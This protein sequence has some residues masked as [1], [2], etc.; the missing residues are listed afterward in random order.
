MI[1]PSKPFPPS[2]L[3]A[4]K[5]PPALLVHRN[6]NDNDNGGG[7]GGGGDDRGD[8]PSS[9]ADHFGNGAMMCVLERSRR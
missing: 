7:G 3:I 9:D 2:L 8:R 6:K 4:I 5:V 1:Y